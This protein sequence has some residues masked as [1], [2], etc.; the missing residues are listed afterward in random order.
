MTEY[1]PPEYD[2]KSG[3]EIYQGTGKVVKD[4]IEYEKDQDFIIDLED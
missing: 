3:K 4:G 1:D 2:S